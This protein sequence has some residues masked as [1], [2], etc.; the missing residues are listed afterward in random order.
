MINEI[1]TNNAP[2]NIER[3]KKTFFII[4]PF[5][6]MDFSNVDLGSKTN[7]ESVGFIS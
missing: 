7:H 6:I 3:L 1:L 4:F 2:A 5:S